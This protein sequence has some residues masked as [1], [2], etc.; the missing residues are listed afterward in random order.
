MQMI[1]I[2]YQKSSILHKFLY[3]AAFYPIKNPPNG[4][5]FI[6]SCTIFYRYLWCNPRYTWSR[7][8]RRTDW[9][10]CSRSGL[11][12]GHSGLSKILHPWHNRVRND[13]RHPHIFL[14]TPPRQHI[15]IRWR[16][17][18]L[19]SRFQPRSGSRNERP[20]YRLSAGTVHA[21]ER[22]SP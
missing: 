4:G 8:I 7:Y 21:A 11:R 12:P 6:P 10:S 15:R 16:I 17:Q 5:F 9:C 19:S 3:K 1:C 20:E 18:Y 13:V 2:F 14:R 22:K